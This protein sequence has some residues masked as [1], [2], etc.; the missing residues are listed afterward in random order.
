MSA[1]FFQEPLSVGFVSRWLDQNC[2]RLVPPVHRFVLHTLSTTYR[3]IEQ[4]GPERNGCGLELATPVLEKKPF[5][6]EKSKPLLP[7]S[8]AWLLAGALPQAYSRPQS[9]PTSPE[10]AAAASSNTSTA[11]HAN[12]TLASQAFMAK[13]L[14]VVP[15]HWTQLYDSRQHGVGANRFLHHLM[16][17]RGPTLVLLQTRDDKDVDM[18]FCVASPTEWR[19]THLYVGGE[20]SCLIQL[21]P[22][23]S[24]MEKGSK[25]LYLNTTIRGYPKGLRVSVDPRNPIIAVDEAFE[26]LDVHSITHKLLAIEVNNIESN[27]QRVVNKKNIFPF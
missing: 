4:D 11:P 1:C 10:G 26:K 24:L 12:T 9:K 15:S 7:I 21:K 17:Y 16:G 13:L 8:V 18:V 27:F 25:I 23:F 5:I 20:D 3:S 19:E 22:K 6:D 14:S 2:P